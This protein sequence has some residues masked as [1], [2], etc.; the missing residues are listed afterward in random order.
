MNQVVVELVVLAGELSAPRLASKPEVRRC[1]RDVE[2]RK[3]LDVRSIDA[4]GIH[5]ACQPCAHG[6]MIESV[7]KVS[8][9]SR[10]ARI[11]IDAPNDKR[12]TQQFRLW[13]I[14]R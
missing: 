4:R 1:D 14:L 12:G 5:V 2:R 7:S 11:C 9:Q 8:R 10:I 3:L 13:V 6:S